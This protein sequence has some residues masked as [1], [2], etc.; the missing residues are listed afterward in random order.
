MGIVKHDQPYDD[1]YSRD[2]IAKARELSSDI[3]EYIVT[4][5]YLVDTPEENLT[6]LWLRN[7]VIGKIIEELVDLGITVCMDPD[8]IMDQPLMV[9]AVMTLRAKF[10]P[11]TWCKFIIDHAEMRD[12]IE[13]LIDDDCIAD[14]IDY[15]SRVMRLDEGWES[16]SKL[17]A[18]RPGFVQSSGKFNDMLKDSFVA[19]DNLGDTPAVPENDMDALLGYSKF[20][21]DR[22]I[23]IRSIASGLHAVNDHGGIPKMRNYIVDQAMSRFEVELSRPGVVRQFLDSEME[24][25]AFVEQRRQFYLTKWKHC[26]EYWANVADENALPSKLEACIMVATLYVD[27]PDSTHASVYVMETFD[28]MQDMFGERYQR[29]R[30]IIE[31]AIGNLA[32]IGRGNES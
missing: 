5:Q 12:D 26:L 1:E 13:Q 2:I 4:Q 14:V 23:A 10:D 27:A 24:P 3:D 15:C 7:K 20:L 32:I 28:N 25:K 16:L 19:C 29:I 6:P 22:K 17:N 8:D 31:V 9:D 21:A 18:N 11:D 30:E